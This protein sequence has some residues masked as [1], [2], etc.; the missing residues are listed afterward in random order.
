MHQL[1]PQYIIWTVCS[2]L[3]TVTCKY[4]LILST[5]GA[6]YPILSYPLTVHAV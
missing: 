4:I 2:T 5:A 1:L 3:V 6:Q